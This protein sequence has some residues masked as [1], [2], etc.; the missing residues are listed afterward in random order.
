MA[1]KLQPC[2][3]TA[4]VH[5]LRLSRVARRQCPLLVIDPLI[6]PSAAWGNTQVTVARRANLATVRMHAHDGLTVAMAMRCG[7]DNT[8]C[9]LLLG[10]W[11]IYAQTLVVIRDRELRLQIVDRIGGRS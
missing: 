8:T 5:M 6:D 7:S 1:V 9:V 2:Y 11:L 3:H 10:L 4:R